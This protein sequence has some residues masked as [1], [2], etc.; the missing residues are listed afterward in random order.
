ME[1]KEMKAL[2]FVLWAIMANS[3]KPF[4]TDM[5]IQSV[6]DIL[7]EKE[8]PGEIADLLKLKA[9][10]DS[11][12]V[13]IDDNVRARFYY[14]YMYKNYAKQGYGGHIEIT[15]K[16]FHFLMHTDVCQS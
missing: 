1:P 9:D 7:T 6:W 5:L 8:S 2:Y 16:G 14:V 12:N 11:G 3:L 10:K 15:E 4:T 13:I